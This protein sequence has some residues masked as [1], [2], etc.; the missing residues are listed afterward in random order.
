MTQLRRV[1]GISWFVNSY[2]SYRLSAQYDIAFGFL[3]VHE[4]LLHEIEHWTD[5]K[6]MLELL[7]KV[8]HDNMDGARKALIDLHQVLPEVCV[9]VNTRQAARIMLNAARKKVKDMEA[10]GVLPELQANMMIAQVALTS[11]SPSLPTPSP[12]PP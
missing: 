5:D 4:H 2:L 3:S 11:P 7:Q 9:A 8:S 1:Y 10:H 6:K 12:L